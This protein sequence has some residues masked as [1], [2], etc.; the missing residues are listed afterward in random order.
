VTRA[1]LVASALVV[2]GIGVVASFTPDIA[3]TALGAPD[4]PAL[5]LMVQLLGAI[6]FGFAVLNGMLRATPLGGIYGRPLVLAN[7]V[8]FLSAT[9]AMAKLLASTPALRF[10][11]P[12]FAVYAALASGFAVVLFRHPF[13]A[14]K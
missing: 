7:L 1:L 3:L 8:H 6:A 14:A 5:R 13:R 12:F 11:W 4:T 10:L 9:L 2:G